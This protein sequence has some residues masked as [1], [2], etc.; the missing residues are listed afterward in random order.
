MTGGVI[1]V[2]GETGRNFGAGMTG[3]AAYVY[4]PG[5]LLPGRYNP[6]L[7]ALRRVALAEHRQEL[8]DL[9]RQH[10]LHTGSPRARQLLQDWERE[11]ANCWRVAPKDAV[12][13]IEAANE[14]ANESNS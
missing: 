3:G 12:A 14:G 5:D 6:Q 7:V 8:R 4:D 2:L 1:V 9:V 11:L 13:T 10:Y